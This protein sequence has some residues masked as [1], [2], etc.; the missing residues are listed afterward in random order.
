MLNIEMHIIFS[1]VITY[2]MWGG[3]GVCITGQ[4]LPVCSSKVK[5]SINRSPKAQR[6][7]GSVFSEPES[8]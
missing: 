3:E 6:L 2:N 1:L 4:R 8:C 5:L 7:D